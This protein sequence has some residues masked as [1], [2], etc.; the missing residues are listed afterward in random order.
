MDGP[1]LILDPPSFGGG[2]APAWKP[3]SEL[4]TDRSGLGNLGPVLAADPDWNKT[5]GEKLKGWGADLVSGPRDLASPEGSALLRSSLDATMYADNMSAREQTLQEAAARRIE[6]IRKATGTTL[7]NPFLGGYSV[8]ARRQVRQQALNNPDYDPRGGIPAA[9]RQIF[10]A[11]VDA[12]R[13]ANPETTD[14]TLD[15]PIE[16]IANNLSNWAEY[17]RAGAAAAYKEA[18][19]SGTGAF[20]AEAAGGFGGRSRDPLTIGSIAL[21]PGGAV[22][23]SILAK[24]ASEAAV[25]GAFNVGIAAAEKPSAEAYRE[26]RGQPT[27]SKL[28]SGEEAAQAFVAGAAMGAGVRGSIET[29]KAAFGAAAR[30]WRADRSAEQ[31]RPPGVASDVHAD[32][33]DQAVRHANDPANEPPPPLITP[34]APPSANRAAELADI[35]RNARSPTEVVEA[36]RAETRERTARAEQ[37]ALELGGAAR[38]Q[39]DLLAGINTEVNQRLRAAEAEVHE[40]LAR[41]EGRT[42]VAPPENVPRQGADFANDNLAAAEADARAR[43]AR[44]EAEARAAVQRAQPPTLTDAALASG[45]PNMVAS[46]KLATLSDP[47]WE[48]VREGRASPDHAIIVAEHVPNPADHAPVLDRLTREAPETAKEASLIAAD[49]VAGQVQKREVAATKEALAPAKLRP[50]TVPEERRSLHQFL[51]GR[52]GIAETPELRDM[53]GGRSSYVRPYGKLVKDYVDLPMRKHGGVYPEHIDRRAQEAFEA[54]YISEPSERALLEALDREARGDKVYRN[55]YT[56]EPSKREVREANKRQEEMFGADV[57]KLIA[58]LGPQSGTKTAQARIRKETIDLLTTGAER[59]ADIALDR[60][61]MNQYER[62]SEGASRRGR[63]AK[64]EAGAKEIPVQSDA[65]AIPGDGRGNEAAG[66][67]GVIG[68]ERGP[69]GV[70]A[71]VGGAGG[72][73]G[74]APQ[75]AG[76][77]ESPEQPSLPGI[78]LDQPKARQGELPLVGGEAAAEAVAKLRE[79]LEAPL[80]GGT[81]PPPKEGLFDPNPQYSIDDL[82][83]S[84]RADGSTV[85]VDPDQVRW[86]SERDTAITQFIRKC[87]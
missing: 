3:S 72:P 16:A 26:S 57:D 37:G 35:V 1:D 60:A 69:A 44:A 75:R 85:L 82:I 45:D 2:P 62:E 5:F 50:G 42:T 24:I 70:G 47:A 41:A 4:T 6:L 10:D 84:Q 36:I 33:L 13:R 12:I 55:G 21:G 58:D 74:P 15:L 77:R 52:G 78:T 14:A 27:T 68:G 49:E 73:G 18:G 23:K 31:E 9:A 67:A 64:A 76:R 22:G 63:K 80:T 79:Q 17:R 71:D 86:Q 34:S 56:P 81:K 28:I 51:A 46:A 20:L 7:E 83:P 61:I 53:F 29:G 8:E 59:D 87:D 30:R 39:G 19:R 32:A 48:A 11:Q 38:E 43:V 40:R 65:G 54:G 25:Q 66:P